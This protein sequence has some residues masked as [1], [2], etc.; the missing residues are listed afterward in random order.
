MTLGLFGYIFQV[1]SFIKLSFASDFRVL[2]WIGRVCRLS[3]L[4]TSFFILS[5]H[6]IFGVWD[7]T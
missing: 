7:D 5:S 1:S 4:F 3:F 2:G 6:M